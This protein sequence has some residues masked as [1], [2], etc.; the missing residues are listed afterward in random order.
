MDMLDESK[1][2]LLF[3]PERRV[4]TRERIDASTYYGERAEV[5]NSLVADGCVIEGRVE[6]CVIFCGVRV[7]AGAVLKNC[8]ILNDT[9]IGRNVELNCVISDKNVSISPYVSLT[10]NTRLPLVIP[11][12]SKI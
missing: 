3:P 10:G 1:R 11:K 4:T 2:T 12:D 6:N 7:A 9:V 5:K 8:I